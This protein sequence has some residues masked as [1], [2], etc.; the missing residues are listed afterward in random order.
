MTYNVAT[1]TWGGTGALSFAANTN[2]VG[3]IRNKFY[4][5]GGESCCGVD[6]HTFNTTWV[7]D[8]SIDR[9]DQR[10]DMPHATKY[11]VTGVIGGRLYVLPGF[12]S[13]ESVDPG[14]C[15]VG[16]RIRQLYRFDPSTSTWQTRA[17]LPATGDRYFGAVFQHRLFVLVLSHSNGLAIVK[18]FAYDP[19][20]NTWKSRRAPPVA[21]PIIRVTLGGQGRLLL[22]NGAST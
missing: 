8:A 21:G 19:A 14:H 3:W 7:Y 10:A 4:Y 20:M 15:D 12:C 13:M 11:G 16:G 2:G 22:V 17:P 1:D 5:T 9:L 6:F 18:A